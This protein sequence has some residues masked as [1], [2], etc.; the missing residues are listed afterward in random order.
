MISSLVKVIPALVLLMTTRML[1]QSF[2][3]TTMAATC[4]NI[5]VKSIS[6]G[7]EGRTRTDYGNHRSQD[8]S[9]A[10]NTNSGAAD[11][12]CLESL[13]IA[14]GADVVLDVG[15]DGDN[16]FGNHKEGGPS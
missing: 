14:S 10:C 13:K 12:D 7:G 2:S 9:D 3:S 4:H 15:A 6:Y 16:T 5:L 11:R 1:M 8:G